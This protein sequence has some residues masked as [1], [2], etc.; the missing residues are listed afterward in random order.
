MSMLDT[1]VY[2]NHVSLDTQSTRYWNDNCLQHINVQS[3]HS[4]K[5]ENRYDMWHVHLVLVCDTMVAW[6]PFNDAVR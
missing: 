3:C 1:R 2:V 5:Y 6:Y 4:I